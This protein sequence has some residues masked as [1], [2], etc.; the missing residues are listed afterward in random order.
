M[1]RHPTSNYNIT[2]PNKGSISFQ[3]TNISGARNAISLLY[4]VSI[5]SKFVGNILHPYKYQF[6]CF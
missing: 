3:Y 1:S 6:P 2:L 4:H 5:I